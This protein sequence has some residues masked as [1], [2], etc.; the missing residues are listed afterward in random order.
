MKI[1]MKALLCLAIALVGTMA[2]QAIPSVYEASC[3]V[4]YW[5]GTT[6]HP[7]ELDF[8]MPSGS[9]EEV[10]NTRA[11]DWRSEK[12]GCM[13]RDRYLTQIG[14]TKASDDMLRRAF[15]S[16]RLERVGHDRIFRIM[17]TSPDAHLAASYANAYA[18]AIID[19]TESENAV[20]C[21][22]AVS[23]ISEAVDHQQRLVE[24]LSERV[25]R[26][27]A[28]QDRVMLSEEH[29]RARE[30]LDGLQRK[31]AMAREIARQSIPLS[32]QVVR[33]AEV[34]S[35]LRKDFPDFWKSLAR[36]R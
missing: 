5:Q 28:P 7:G 10:L 13:A 19:F 2:W 34:P 36:G 24:R 15:D 31:L 6:R 17:V 35:S 29:A 27:V 3:D 30:Q 32:L 9:Y 18:R 22:K 23:Q 8:E 26:E 11:G 20:R 16:M 14:P 1:E 33:P 25:R 4:A 12:V 21:E